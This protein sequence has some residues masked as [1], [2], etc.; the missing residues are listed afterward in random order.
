MKLRI[1]KERIID[2]LQKAAGILP[3]KTGAS[4]LR[5]LWLLADADQLSIMATDATLEFSGVYATEVMEPGLAG[6][7]GKAFVDLMRQLPAGEILLTLDAQK[8]VLLLEQGKRQY[9]LPA[10][11]G[12]W[13]Q[14]F[15]PF[16]EDGAVVWS[17]D[18]LQDMLERLVFCISDDDERDAL[19]CLYMKACGGGRIEACGL[20]GHQFALFGFLHDELAARLPQEGILLQKK[21]LSELK[22]WLGQDEIELNITDKRVYLRT[23][24]KRE[25]LSLPRSSASYPEYGIFLNRL[26]DPAVSRLCLARKDAMEALGRIQIFNTESD[27]CVYMDLHDQESVLSAQGQDT[28]SARESLETRYSGDLTRIAFPTRNLMDIM[29]HFLSPELE[30]VF[31]GQEGPCGISGK[32]DPD[33]T[34]IIMPMKIAQEA[35]FSEEA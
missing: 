17:G 18:F 12:S 1:T 21:Y 5:C 11:D 27:R 14:Q 7:Q 33:Y 32:E 3:S 4:Y 20:N 30:M 24:D 28:G 23:I 9:R 10:Q 26:R 34:V 19:S 13:F 15:T 2:G 29:G 6:V 16:P 35:Y 31:T 8:H 25:C 22:K